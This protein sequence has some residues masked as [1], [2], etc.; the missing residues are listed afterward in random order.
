MARSASALGPASSPLAHA[1]ELTATPSRPANV[2]SNSTGAAA[3]ATAMRSPPAELAT[4][5]TAVSEVEEPRHQPARAAAL[6]IER[7]P[8]RGSTR[9]LEHDHRADRPGGGFGAHTA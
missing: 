2:A 5:P 8:V 3:S 1:S 6:E 9:V 4:A 7:Q